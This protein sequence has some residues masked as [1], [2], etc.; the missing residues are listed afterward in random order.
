M[1]QTVILPGRLSG[2]VIG[3]LIEAIVDAY[4]SRGKLALFLRVRLDKRIDDITLEYDLQIVAFHLVEKAERERWLHD[5]V[6]A[7]Y[8]DTRN[9]RVAAFYQMYTSI[10]SKQEELSITQERGIPI[11]CEGN[12]LTLSLWGL[13]GSETGWGQV[14]GG[15][16][17]ALV[18]SH[19]ETVP[20]SIIRVS[21][22]G[23][24]RMDASFVGELVRLVWQDCLH[25][26]FCLVDLG[27]KDLQTN[28]D[29]A[30]WRYTRP[31]FVWNARMEYCLLGPEPSTGLR[32]TLQY[33]LSVERSTASEV[34]SALHLK[35]QNASNKLKQLWHEGYVFRQEQSAGSGGLEYEYVRVR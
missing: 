21:L 35:I 28:W 29:M 9:A 13:M 6:V 32:E 16:V 30:A 24:Q 33:V 18:R 2:G 12:G 7:L 15:Q 20:T 10:L 23:I 11:V 17:A 22:G 19:V 4:R 14:Q 1:E 27:D 25:H 34:S 26:R 8:Q 3:K 5:L 31:I